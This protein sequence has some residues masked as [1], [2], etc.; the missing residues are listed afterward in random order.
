[1]NNMKSKI[2][3]IRKSK[4]FTYIFIAVIIIAQLLYITYS[5][6]S[7]KKGY[8]SD[9][10]YSYGLSNSHQNPFLCIDGDASGDY[11]NIN[12]WV[13]GTL[14]NDYLVVNDGEAFDYANV[15]Y[16]Q[17]LDRH[18]PLYYAILHTV[19]SF[20]PNQFSP[21]FGFSINL[22]FFAITQLFLFLLARKLL[23]S[24]WLAI[25]VCFC[26]GFSIGAMNTVVFI[27]M[28]AML[29]MWVVISAYIHLKVKEDGNKLRLKT[30]IPL[31]I[32]TALGAL[33]QHEFT[34]V[35]YAFAICFCLHYLANKDIK[36]FF[37]YG[38]T[39]LGG[40]LLSWAIFPSIPK[41]IF[42]EGGNAIS[43]QTMS[44]QI[45]ETLDYIFSE[46]FGLSGV[47]S[48][49]GGAILLV[50]V[51]ISAIIYSKNKL[52]QKTEVGEEKLSV[53]NRLIKWFA[54]RD[55]L[56]MGIIASVIVIAITTIHS[57]DYSTMG[58]C[59]RYLFSIY[60]FV[61]L[62][63]ISVIMYLIYSIK[64]ISKTTIKKVIATVLFVGLLI[65]NIICIKPAYFF[66]QTDYTELKSKLDNN[67]VIVLDLI[68]NSLWRM[69]CFSYCFM[70]A[71]N[72]Y[73]SHYDDFINNLENVDSLKTEKTV[74]ILL[75]LD[76]KTKYDESEDKYLLK[77][78]NSK[79]EDFERIYDDEFIQK[80]FSGLNF[81]QNA[82]K[83]GIVEIHATKYLLYVME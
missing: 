12:E 43:F 68:S 58:Y 32:V 83:Q 30:L 65:T 59:D 50:V 38:F 63:V 2:Y 53:I 13:S 16:N 40:I 4:V 33:T 82:I 46:L 17:S 37:I 72:V 14:M 23:K 55:A 44:K 79:T 66:P 57:V 22:V 61:V 28:Y 31:L 45:W 48:V 52:N 15:W 39:M 18:P 54:T 19:C 62:L 71:D 20:F 21:W 81:Y 6:S 76:K 3:N 34:I 7:E 11:I 5:F 25:L 26:Y 35:S 67:E 8:H 78:F 1:M 64:P 36:N 69:V 29:T 80:Y 77:F 9:E 24:N 41:Q 10:M 27:R 51:L 70:N 75:A 42:S 73:F 56:Y 47:W 49:V 74:Y 60:P